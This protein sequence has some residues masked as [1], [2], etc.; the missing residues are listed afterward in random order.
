MIELKKTS[1]EDLASLFL[2]QTNEEGIWMA[3]FTAENPHDKSAYLDKWSAIVENPQIRMQTI[4][5]ENIVVGSVIHFEVME[6][7]NVSY[8]IDRSY[9]GKGIAT[10]ALKMFINDSSKRPLFARVAHDNYR[11]QKVLENCGFKSV[12][13]EKGFANARKKEIEEFVYQLG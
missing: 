9:W 10:E 5:L 3:A 11:S 6:E 2:F 8:W 4:R 12:G 13:K 1:I 7:T